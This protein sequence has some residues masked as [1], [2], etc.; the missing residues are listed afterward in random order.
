MAGNRKLTDFFRTTTVT[1]K[2]P[3]RDDRVGDTI[4]VARNNGDDTKYSNDGVPVLPKGRL[5][6]CGSVELSSGTASGGQADAFITSSQSVMVTHKPVVK[7]GKLMVRSSDSEDTDSNSSFGDLDELLNPPKTLGPPA[8]DDRNASTQLPDR[9]SPVK[10]TRSRINKSC[11]RT[12]S[13]AAPR[14]KFSMESL[15]MHAERDNTSAAS[16]ARARVALDSE[17]RHDGSLS[18]E[19][20][21]CVRD[22]KMTEA[23]DCTD[24]TDG[25]HQGLLASII[26][27]KGEEGGFQKVISAMKRTEALS[28]DKVWYFF[29]HGSSSIARSSR[30]ALPMLSNVPSGRGDALSG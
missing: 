8:G 14:Y 26:S 3:K 9:S 4:V 12:T 20:E 29:E 16:A 25:I 22:S 24:G 18:Y 5:S 7:K 10:R 23:R 1:P 13:P 28:R 15:V 30:T 11:P 19:D 21:L 6:H 2:V 17:F 27:E